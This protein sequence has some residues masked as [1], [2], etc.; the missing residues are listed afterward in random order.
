MGETAITADDA[1]KAASDAA[2]A[3][4]REGG[5]EAKPAGLDDG[6]LAAS[7]EAEAQARGEQPAP[8][9]EPQYRQ[10]DA[11]L[12]RAAGL[13]PEQLGRYADENLN[14]LEPLPSDASEADV[15]KRASLI[16]QHRQGQQ[17]NRAR[18]AEVSQAIGQAAD[19]IDYEGADL[20][21][22][23]NLLEQL[24]GPEAAQALAERV[25]AE[26][27]ADEYEPPETAGEWL[28]QRQALEQLRAAAAAAQAQ[29]QQERALAENLQAVQQAVTEFKQQHPDDADELGPAM[30][31]ILSD[32]TTLQQLV[33]ADGDGRRAM[34][35]DVRSGALE[36]A[37]ASR[38]AAAQAQADLEGERWAWHARPGEA[39]PAHVV[40]PAAAQA[41]LE[42][43]QQALVPSLVDEA[44][45]L[46]R[47]LPDRAAA[48]MQAQAAERDSYEREV[49][50]MARSGR[51][52]AQLRREGGSGDVW[53]DAFDFGAAS[54]AA[55]AAARTRQAKAR[56]RS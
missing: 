36:L 56:A 23:L 31:E 26:E 39:P 24:H 48:A 28:A 15:L 21:E 14:D 42:Q 51:T 54:D 6:F 52:L 49:G 37:R 43:R 7:R 34:L 44:A 13:D 46:A 50:E 25:A 19:A 22:T 29:R 55:E 30:F 45:V 18:L 11:D 38:S 3:A 2:E 8:E 10:D 12:I 27:Q 20:N 16:E 9:P 47:G 1:F 41:W 35:D 32:P 5:Q 4:A 33:S 17:Q 53:G 40:D